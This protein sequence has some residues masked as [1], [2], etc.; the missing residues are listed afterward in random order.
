VIRNGVDPARVRTSTSGQAAK[1]KLGLDPSRGVV[2]GYLGRFAPD[3]DPLAAADAC[4]LLGSG[5]VPCMVGG[6]W[7]EE[8]TRENAKASCPWVHLVDAQED[9]ALP[10]KAFDVMVSTAPEEGFNLSLVEAW[11][12]GV[13]TVTRRTG[14]AAEGHWSDVC[15]I[16]EGE[17][18][19]DLA[20]LIERAAGP[21]G[22]Q[23]ARR[24][25]KAALA[26]L[27]VDRFH[28][29]WS[30]FVKQSKLDAK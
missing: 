22:K 26:E 30:E 2:V 19:R 28:R 10:L 6:G 25:K 24:A 27:S 13:P 20:K 5:W 18:R 3:K 21:V 23:R 17:D 9:V 11:M 1:Q 8:A 29:S 12:A 14:I 15:F 16:W 7:A 4:S